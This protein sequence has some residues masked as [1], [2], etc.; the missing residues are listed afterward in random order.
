MCQKKPRKR[1]RR[2]RRSRRRKRRRRREPGA[3][4]TLKHTPANKTQS[5]TLIL[6]AS[7]FTIMDGNG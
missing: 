6:M 2:K 4:R 1:R 5:T 7:Y 3:E